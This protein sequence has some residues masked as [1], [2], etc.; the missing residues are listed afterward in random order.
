M[1][2][3]LENIEK[4]SYNVLSESLNLSFDHFGL[5]PMIINKFHVVTQ[6][7]H[8]VLQASMHRHFMEA[9]G[10]FSILFYFIFPCLTPSYSIQTF[11]ILLKKKEREWWL[12]S[13]LIS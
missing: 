4:L 12:P 5:C 3:Y 6:Y 7:A 2:I 13:K 10:V 9:A 8:T 1:C 11:S